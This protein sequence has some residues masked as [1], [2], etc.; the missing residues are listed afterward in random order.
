LTRWVA[1][2][3]GR[4]TPLHFSRF[5]P[6]YQMANLPPTPAATLRR[7]KE[8]AKGEGLYHVYLGNLVEPHAEDTLCH[9]CGT[10]LVERRGYLVL[11][12]RVDEG[13]C[14]NCKTEV[15]GLWK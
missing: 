1:E 6:Q 14:P 7:A 8:I 4:E 9:G 10:L 5:F 2:N 13:K 11:Q 12:N 15:H 3:L